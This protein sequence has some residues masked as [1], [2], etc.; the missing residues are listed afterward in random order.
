MPEMFHC[1]YR[2]ISKSLQ[3]FSGFH[4]SDYDSVGLLLRDKSGPRVLFYSS[5]QIYDLE[6]GEVLSLPFFQDISARKLRTKQPGLGNVG[7]EFRAQT[8]NQKIE[9]GYFDFSDPAE[10][11]V[12]YW[13]YAELAKDLE[14]FQI[15][16]ENIDCARPGLL[17]NDLAEYTEP[18]ILRTEL[19]K[20]EVKNY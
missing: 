13:K 20:L 16:V 3:S 11:I 4:K 10:L 18:I 17:K 1:Y 6:Y 12:K 2:K 7:I 9:N 19:S 5:N 8:V 15:S 14:D